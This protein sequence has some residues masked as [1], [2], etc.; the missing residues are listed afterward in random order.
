MAIR[1]FFVVILWLTWLLQCTALTEEN[2]KLY[3][4]RNL[5]E[6]KSHWHTEKQRICDF[7]T[8]DSYVSLACEKDIYKINNE[9]L[10]HNSFSS[11]VKRDEYL[12]IGSAYSFG[13]NKRN[14]VLKRRKRG[15]FQECCDNV[16]GCCWE[17]LAEYCQN[18]NRRINHGNIV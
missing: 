2:K 1:L 15:I 7:H 5:E 18:N 9:D 14:R 3:E 11:L 8:I 16:S 4:S 10:S 6:W 17:E 13:I 12:P